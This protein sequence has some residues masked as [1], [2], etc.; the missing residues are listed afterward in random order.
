MTE[1]IHHER[2]ME[3]MLL[4]ETVFVSWPPS[5]AMPDF[6]V[7]NQAI[8]EAHWDKWAKKRD[9]ITVEIVPT[10]TGQMVT[11]VRIVWRDVEV[12]EKRTHE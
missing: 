5:L 10:S 9:L 6:S 1:V 12:K 2:V 4:A 3:P 11:L 7:I 8:E